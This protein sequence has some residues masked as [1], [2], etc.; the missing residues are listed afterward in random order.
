MDIEQIILY[1]GLFQL[2]RR[3]GFKPYPPPRRPDLNPILL[4][5]AGGIG[6]GAGSGGVGAGIVD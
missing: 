5:S 4:L 3:I 6:P 2:I 1:A